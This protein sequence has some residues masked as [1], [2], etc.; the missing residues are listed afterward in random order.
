MDLA[1]IKEVFNKFSGKPFFILVPAVNGTLLIRLKA[2]Q[3][4]I[5]GGF[6]PDFSCVFLFIF[7]IQII[8][9]TD[10]S[11]IMTLFCGFRLGLQ[12]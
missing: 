3:S 7:L 1:A 10:S 5:K 4:T 11:S 6:H 2:Y 8:N 12:S 9:R